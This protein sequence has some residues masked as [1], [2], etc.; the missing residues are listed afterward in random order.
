MDEIDTMIATGHAG[1]V[2]L[3]DALAKIGKTIPFSK[4]KH[5]LDSG[6]DHLV[7]GGFWL[8]S[9]HKEAA[10]YYSDSTHLFINSKVPEIRFS[11]CFIYLFVKSKLSL[12]EKST[13]YQ[14]LGDRDDW[15]RWK[16]LG[17]FHAIG[18]AEFE[19]D[20]GALLQLDN[21]TSAHSATHS[22]IINN[23]NPISENFDE[24]LL[25]DSIKA[26]CLQNQ[27]GCKTEPTLGG[28]TQAAL[29]FLE[30]RKASGS[31]R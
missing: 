5:L 31:G 11:L 6:N 3:N 1:G 25:A 10:D 16:A 15:V 23:S 27:N 14:L 8:L 21:W 20:V 13:Y 7:S 30:D 12:I 24:K 4:I 22:F 2:V 19:N 9:E 18:T 17:I 29:D 28:F 26:L